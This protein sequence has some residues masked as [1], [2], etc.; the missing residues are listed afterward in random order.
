MKEP[1]VINCLI[2]L[3]V[4]TVGSTGVGFG[5]VAFLDSMT[6]FNFADDVTEEQKQEVMDSYNATKNMPLYAFPML[7]FVIGLTASVIP[8]KKNKI[9][10]KIGKEVGFKCTD[11]TTDLSG[12]KDLFLIR[13]V[14]REMFCIPCGTKRKYCNKEG[15][16]VES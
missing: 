16:A 5:L 12:D 7:G 6:E 4:F 13:T 3:L 1:K 14:E 9:M 15:Y 8:Y 11:C 2:I 10:F